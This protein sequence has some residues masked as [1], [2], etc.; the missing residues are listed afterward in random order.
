MPHIVEFTGVPCCGKSTLSHKV[1]NQLSENRNINE[2]QFDLSHGTNGTKRILAKLYRAAKYCMRHPARAIQARNMFQ[3]IE[4]LINYYYI[5]DLCSCKEMVILE[6]GCCQ[7][8]MSL[9]EK[10][11]PCEE[12]IEAIIKQ[13]P[14]NELTTVVFVEASHNEIKDRAKHRPENDQPYF[15]NS[16]NIDEEIE[17]AIMTLKMI[18]CAVDK[19][20]IG[21]IVVENHTGEED[22]AAQ[23][24][25]VALEELENK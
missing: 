16:V 17:T 2:K 22:F 24:I 25:V 8:I 15:L 1:A 11:K 20:N 7:M 9:F 13:M 23:S 10:E 18:K 3:S 5:M 14:F 12:K 4:G 19:R 21:T 6:Q